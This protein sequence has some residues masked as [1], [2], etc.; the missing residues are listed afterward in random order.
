MRARRGAAVQRRELDP[1][2][3]RSAWVCAHQLERLSLPAL[4]PVR[5]DG[6]AVELLLPAGARESAPTPVDVRIARRKFEACG[7]F[8]TEPHWLAADG[9]AWLTN[10]ECFAIDP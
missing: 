8:A 2:R 10:P 1:E 5:L 6:A 7:R 3:A 9:G 4:R